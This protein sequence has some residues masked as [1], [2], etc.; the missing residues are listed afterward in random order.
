MQS[1]GFLQG[2]VEELE[3]GETSLRH[4]LHHTET[5]LLIREKR[6]QEL[7]ARIEEERQLQHSSASRY[8]LEYKP[9]GTRRLKYQLPGRLEDQP[10]GRLKHKPPGRL[11]HQNL[12][13]PR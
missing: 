3:Q 6:I 11:E 12:G 8:R 5:A 7:E 9:P 4:T 1:T 13:E 2:R 10:P